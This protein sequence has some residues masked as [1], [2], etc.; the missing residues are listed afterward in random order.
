MLQSV[1]GLDA[2]PFNKEW[3]DVTWEK[4]TL[5]Q[6]LNHEF[7]DTAFG[8]EESEQI[9]TSLVK[10]EKSLGMMKVFK[11]DT[12]DKIFLLSSEEAN[13]YYGTDDARKCQPTE[14]AI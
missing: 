11:K 10:P 2:V 8:L 6:W 3:K 9:Q 4:C 14:Y 13:K 1:Y 12:L 7:Y 5:R